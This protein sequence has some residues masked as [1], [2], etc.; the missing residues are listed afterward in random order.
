M[1]E[2]IAK[3][4]DQSKESEI[5]QIWESSGYFN[6]DN[7]SGKPYTII[8]PPPNATG[9]LHIGHTFEHTIQDIAIRFARMRGRKALWLPG[10]DHAAIATNTKVEK[11]LIKET[12]QNRHQIG[13]EKFIKKVEEFVQ[14]SRGT[15]QNQLRVIG[16]SADWSR[17]AF[18]MDEERTLAVRTAF[19]NMFDAGLVYRGIRVINWDPKGQTAVSDDEVVYKPEQG[20]LYYF[21]YSTDFPITIA[22][23][24]PETKLGDAAVAVNPE[25]SRY[26]QFVGK[27]Y[28]VGFMGNKLKIRIVADETVDPKFG[29]GAVGVTP[30]HSITD[31]EIAQRHKLP[32]IQIINEYGKMMDNTQSL[33]GKKTK[34]AREE[35]VAW[36]KENN[37]LEKIEDVELNITTAERSGGIIEPLP[38][39]Q[40][41]ID[42]NKKFP[43]KHSELK[44]IETGQEVTLKELMRSVVSSGEIQ[45]LPEREEKKYF[46]WIDNLRDWNIS[47]QLW[48]GHR[49][50]VW[51]RNDEIYCGLEAPGGSNWRQDEDTLDTWFSSALWTFTTLGW[52]K[53]TSDLQTFHPTQFMSPGYEILFP[54]VA[55]MILMST[56][57]LGQIPFE[58]AYIHGIVRN[59]D[60]Q[61]FSKSLDNGIDPVDIVTKYGADALRMALVVGVG[62]GNDVKYDEMKV[63]GYRN[64]ANKIWN[65]ARFV[66]N[67]APQPP[68]YQSG[69]DRTPVLS[70]ELLPRDQKIIDELRELVTR[71]TEQMEKYDF[72]HAS[73]DLYH[74]FWHTFA[75]K[76]IEEAKPKLADETTKASA[77]IMLMTSLETLLKLLH[78]FMPFV[79]ETIWQLNHKDL[80]MIRQ[81]P[82][83]VVVSS[84]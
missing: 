12:G 72:A 48:Y 78:P 34:D 54:W 49:I 25:D 26:K 81:W 69:G 65:A 37:L 45:I 35:V 83:E 77:Q 62:T 43:I 79:T 58:I 66:Y 51:Y 30:A 4:Y 17:E 71:I 73:E 32:T 63:K 39:L 40:W 24:R 21:K 64:F 9:T 36:L 1:N 38:K 84:K 70:G 68:L 44:N 29:T 27:E 19:K 22:T 75:D 18:T 61:K 13:R 76:I 50:P 55:R 47:R 20:K 8:M 59:K 16:D 33:A 3:S 53:K 7:L 6:P 5:Y 57:H 42:V 82:N 67:N 28:E 56:F 11:I 15:I 41:F 52:P 74:Y 60:G 46:H 31:Y 2:E 23:T 14:G 10:T 80:L